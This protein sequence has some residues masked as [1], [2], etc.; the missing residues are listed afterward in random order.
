[1]GASMEHGKSSSHSDRQQR[2]RRMLEECGALIED[3]HF[4]Y[5]S[6]QHGPGWIAKDVINMDPARPHALGNMLAE[7]IEESGCTP[8]LVCGPAIGGVI[9][10]QYTALALGVQ[11]VFAERVRTDACE[12]FQLKRRYDEAVNGRRVLVVDDVINTGHSTGQV[13]EA[14]KA[15]GGNVIAVAT[16]ISRGNVGA[17][18]FA[19]DTFICLD[20][21]DLPSFP[22]ATCELCA[23][24]VPINTHYAHGAEFVAG[25]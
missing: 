10:A 14:V 4:V 13:L 11:C 25:E 20:E 2:I 22:A 3:D 24:S 17:E 23:Q 21:V 18:D 12:G 16:W 9:C 19:V 7:A 6:G 1:V 5:A 15:A 8:D